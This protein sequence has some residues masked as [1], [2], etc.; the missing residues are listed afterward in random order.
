MSLRNTSSA[1]AS[2]EPPT[3]IAGRHF[4]QL[5][6]Q[7]IYQLVLLL[8]PCGDEVTVWTHSADDR[9]QQHF[10][11]EAVLKDQSAKTNQDLGLRRTWGHTG[12]SQEPVELRVV[13]TLPHDDTYRP[14]RLGDDV[15][16][17]R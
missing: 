4:V 9:P 2:R 12:L 10:L 6:E 14:G 16:R 8:V 15:G 5:C 11:G 3:G 7:L 1:W 17:R 13:A